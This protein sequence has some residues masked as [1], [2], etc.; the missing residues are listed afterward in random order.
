MENKPKIDTIYIDLDGVVVDLHKLISAHLQ[1]DEFDLEKEIKVLSCFNRYEEKFFPI[2]FELIKKESFKD[3][4]EK[5][6]SNLLKILYIPLWKSRGITVEFLSS[7][8]KTNPLRE[9][10]KKQKREWVDNHYPGIILN[11]V[12]G[13]SFKKDFARPGALLIDDSVSNV[14]SFKAY[15]GFGLHY[16]NLDNVAETLSLLKLV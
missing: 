12:D 11:L 15:G 13:S 8:M 16:D 3:A 1:V 5:A 2:I 14:L 9:S 7:T 6:F 10:L 4:P